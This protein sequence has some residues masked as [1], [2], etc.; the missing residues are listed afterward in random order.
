M[1]NSDIISN[2]PDNVT[3]QILARLPIRDAVRTSVLS[4]NW[5]YKWTTLPH[6]VFDAQGTH[7][8]TNPALDL[9]EDK[10]FRVIYRIL[11]Q[12]KGP[13]WKFSP[14]SV[15]S[16][17]TSFL[18]L[19]KGLRISC[20]VMILGRDLTHR[21]CMIPSP[22]PTFGG[23][24]DLTYLE[25]VRVS[26]NNEGFQNLIA[27]CPKLNALVQNLVDGLNEL[28]I[29]YA[30]SLAILTFHGSPNYIC[31][32]KTPH[33]HVVKEIR[34]NNATR[35]LLRKLTAASGFL[36]ILEM[37]RKRQGMKNSDIISNLP[38]N[39]TERILARLPIRDAVRTS[40]LSRNWRHKWTTLPHLVFDA[41]G[42]HDSTNTAL[43]ED[44]LVR[45]IYRI[46]CQ[47]KG[48]VNKFSLSSVRSMSTSYPDIDQ[49]IK[50][51]LSR[52]GIRELIL[53][54]KEGNWY[55]IHC[56][57]FSCANLR[58]LNLSCCIIP[59]PPPT[60][61][62]F[63][64]L[65][66]LKLNRVSVKTEVLE[67]LVAKCPKLNTLLLSYVDDLDRLNI[68]YAPKLK[69]LIFVGSLN[70]C[71]NNT[72]R[73]VYAAMHFTQLPDM[74][75]NIG[76][77][78]STSLINNLNCLSNLTTFEAG[79]Y[80]LKFLAQGGVR[81]LLPS[82]FKN[83]TLVHFY[84]LMF[85][86]IDSL[87]SFIGLI[88]SSPNLVTLFVTTSRNTNLA[89]GETLKGAAKYL[90]EESRSFGCL[91]KLRYVEMEDVVGVR[92]E[93]ELIKLILGKSPSLEQMKFAPN[94]RV[95]GFK[96]RESKMVK[97]LIRFPR[98]SKIAEI[99]YED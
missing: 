64:D 19:I 8:S 26:V 17:S 56:C 96:E 6:L 79:S 95:D 62:G 76:T 69:T 47:H 2:L 92:P 94:K 12:H 60:F 55:K 72:P 67:N 68:D 36:I 53:L 34:K 65:T 87:S 49:W 33:L 59:T 32:K 63:S 50:Y 24:N 39:I 11:C 52:N 30:P 98:A 73:L 42:T 22:P 71:L 86:D 82:S 91:M 84:E 25:L 18:M 74:N 4:R 57:L 85:E 3:E 15:R 40:V 29:D 77:G 54:F 1:K 41:Q 27:K 43:N 89:T 90:E 16:M 97:D 44:K 48:P 75:E 28:Y 20:R 61:G 10:P 45:V 7:D 70:I 58:H 38:K 46:L 81:E 66:C 93:M 99:I 83:L 9:D 51:F 5:R 88:T 21:Y 31:L 13:I 23:F 78:R 80:F 14:S 35:R 37:G